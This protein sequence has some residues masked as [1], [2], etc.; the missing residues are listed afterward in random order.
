MSANGIW[1]EDNDHNGII[2]TLRQAVDQ[3]VLP[4]GVRSLCDKNDPPLD[5]NTTRNVRGHDVSQSPTSVGFNGFER[6]FSALPC[7]PCFSYPAPMPPPSTQ[8]VGETFP[9]AAVE[10][11]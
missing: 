1:Q 10:R 3:A 7:P 9:Q 4:Q 2:Q 6:A 5:L 8:V 11:T